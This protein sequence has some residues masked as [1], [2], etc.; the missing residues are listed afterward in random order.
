MDVTKFLPL[1]IVTL[2]ILNLL[3]AQIAIGAPPD[4]RQLKCDLEAKAWDSAKK[5]FKGLIFLKPC[6]AVDDDSDYLQQF[7]YYCFENSK[8][9]SCGYEGN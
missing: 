4:V 9:L 8:V 7:D 2:M 5:L 3:Y 1:G 6:A